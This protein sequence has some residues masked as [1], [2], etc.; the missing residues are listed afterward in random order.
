MNKKYF[1]QYQKSI[2][3]LCSKVKSFLNSL[4]IRTCHMFTV[5]IEILQNFHN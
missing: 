4:I 2:K 1:K 5:I 3:S